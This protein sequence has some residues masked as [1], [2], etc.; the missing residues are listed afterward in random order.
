MTKCLPSRA[1]GIHLFLYVS[2]FSTGKIEKETARSRARKR[3]PRHSSAEVG[4]KMASDRGPDNI[5]DG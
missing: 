2:T 1:A 3:T 4:W 5:A